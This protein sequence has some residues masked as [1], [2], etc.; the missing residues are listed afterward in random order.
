M[1]GVI[2]TVI[3]LYFYPYHTLTLLGA[4]A[5]GVVTFLYLKHRRKSH[6]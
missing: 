2:G 6:A 4:I 5:L 1:Y 3:T